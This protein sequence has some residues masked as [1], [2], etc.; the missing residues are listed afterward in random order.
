VRVVPGSGTG[1]LKGISGA[2]TIKIAEG[3]HSY[4][5]DYT[6]PSTQ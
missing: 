4:E 6:L 2:M 1:D 5:L 3:K